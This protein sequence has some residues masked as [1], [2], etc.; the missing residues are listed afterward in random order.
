[1]FSN[2][3]RVRAC[4]WLH[5]TPT[6]DIGRQSAD[7]STETSLIRTTTVKAGMLALV[8]AFLTGACGDHGSATTVS[9]PTPTFSLNG[10]VTDSTNASGIVG[11]TVRIVDGPNVGK[12]ATTDGSGSYSITGL[13]PSGFTVNVYANNYGSQSIGV[14]LTSTETLSFRLNHPPPQNVTLTGQ[15]TDG[16]TSAPISGATIS[17]NGKYTTATDSFGN[18]RVAGVLDAGGTFNYT[19]VTADDYTSDYRSIR[20]MSQNVHLY[21]VKRIAAGDSTVVTVAPDDTLCVN[22]VQDFPALGR[23]YVCRS[24]RV[25]ALSDGIM[26]LE[27]LSTQDGTLPLL[28]LKSWVPLP[29]AL[30]AWGTPRRFS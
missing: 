5:E 2:D 16:A 13:Q 26:T 28:K 15:V 30:N 4:Q 17:I 7:T 9:S 8:F 12:S 24:V 25:V 29:A 20:A 3:A 27:A 18:Y 21:R 22:N 10:T 1:M 19:Y 6:T 14:T 23:D 11:A